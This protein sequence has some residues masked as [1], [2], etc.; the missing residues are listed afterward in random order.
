MSNRNKYKLVASVVFATSIALSMACSKSEESKPSPSG[1][2]TGTTPTGTGTGTTPTGTTPTPA[3]DKPGTATITG[4][5]MFEGAPPKMEAL[6]RQSDPFC[7]KTAKNRPDVTV[8]GGGV[9]DVLVRLPVG[10]AKGAAPA[11]AA[12]VDQKECMYVPFVTGIVSGQ[13]VK[14][15]NSDG[16]THNVHSYVGDETKFNEAQPSG[17]AP[18]EKELEAEAGEVMKLKCDV[19]AWMESYVVV[20]D[21]PYFAVTGDDGSFK[22]SNVPA[23]TYKLEAWHP[24]MG[25][26]TVE[27]TVADGATVE[28]KV[29]A[30]AAADYKK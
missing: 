21:H 26:K 10:A 23:G 24:K 28:A 30:F 3:S 6:A 16:T 5:V 29:P 11:E 9:K 7:A 17:S 12:H 13:K 4:K 20:T 2:G 27:V 19:H 15:T 8:T 14:V 22:I 1:T 18:V 25:V